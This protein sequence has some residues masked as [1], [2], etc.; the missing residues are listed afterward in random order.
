MTHE[1]KE[2]EQNIWAGKGVLITGASRG[3]GEALARWFAARGARVGMVARGADA[4]NRAAHDIRADGG[5]VETIAADVSDKEAIYAIAAAAAER[6]GPVEL[7]VHCAS[8][9]GPLPMP[10]LLDT[11]CEDLAAVLETNLV[12]PFRLTKA[13][14]GPMVLRGQGT[15]VFISSDAAVNGYPRWGA[16]GISKAAQD[17]LAR[18]WAAE[19]EGTGVR[20]LTVD[21]GE[22]DTAMH[23]EAMPD[24]DPAT[25]AD[26]AD[27]AERVAAIID[28]AEDIPSGSRIV[29][30]PW[31]PAARAAAG[32]R[33]VA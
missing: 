5:E 26:P 20:M 7:L 4:L 33:A 16:Y 3:L 22:M 27:V 19:L 13:V 32:P 17:H 2:A 21:P 30:S 1:A 15:V 6:I 29:V 12:G 28:A 23:A 31:A 10:V 25:L 24:A 14:L 11:A 18:I 8:T 9:L